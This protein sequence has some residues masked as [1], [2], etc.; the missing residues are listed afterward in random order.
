MPPATSSPLTKAA[1]GLSGLYGLVSL[2]G[3]IIGFVKANSLPSLLAGGGAGLLL[4]CCAFLTLRK[5]LAGL[6]G[7]AV[8][9]LA[10][11]GRFVPGVLKDEPSPVALVMTSGGVLVLLSSGL[12]LATRPGSR[13]S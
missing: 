3:G 2:T 7:S 1:A 10:L 11:L 13:G 9:A 12:A 8:I 5:P 6:I 4:L